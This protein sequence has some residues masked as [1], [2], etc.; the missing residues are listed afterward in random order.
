[1]RMSTC[2]QRTQIAPAGKPHTW[3]TALNQT[4]N[5]VH[6]ML[7]SKTVQWIKRRHTQ[8]HGLVSSVKIQLNEDMRCQR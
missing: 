4:A 8:H 3:C 6:K 7:K 2:T 5:G 1:M